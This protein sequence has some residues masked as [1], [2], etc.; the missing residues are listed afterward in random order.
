MVKGKG[1]AKAG[2]PAQAQTPPSQGKDL[3]LAIVDTALAGCLEAGLIQPSNAQVSTLHLLL[4]DQTK[5]DLRPSGLQLFYYGTCE[6]LK[7]CR[8]LPPSD[9]ESSILELITPIFVL[10]PQCQQAVSCAYL[11]RAD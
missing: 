4:I 11:L 3:L 5:A 6:S 10:H 9:L 8:R 7:H 2:R 1:K